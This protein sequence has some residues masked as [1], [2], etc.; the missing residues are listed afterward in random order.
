MPTDPASA[1]PPDLGRRLEEVRTAIAAEG[2][3]KGLAGTVQGAILRLLEV[4]LAILADFRAGRLAAVAPGAAATDA[5]PARRGGGP[6]SASGGCADWRA[7]GGAM[8]PAPAG[9]P[10]LRRLEGDSF[11]TNPPDGSPSARAAEEICAGPNATHRALVA[12][13]SGPRERASTLRRRVSIRRGPSGGHRRAPARMAAPGRRVAAECVAASPGDAARRDGFSKNGCFGE[14]EKR[15]HI[16]SISKRTITAGDM[17]VR[18]RWCAHDT[19]VR[20]ATRAPACAA[21]SCARATAG[22]PRDRA[23]AHPARRRRR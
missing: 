23:G 14:R 12:A 17:D 13:A 7:A 20:R 10:G 9:R 2:A 21:R 1:T 15:G 11:E 3:R 8:E 16:V 19:V 18:R 5:D 22:D 6:P 4:L